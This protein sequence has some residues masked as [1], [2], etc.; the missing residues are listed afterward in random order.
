MALLILQLFTSRLF[1]SH[2]EKLYQSK[3]ALLVVYPD[4]IDYEV[5][6]SGLLVSFEGLL[7]RLSCGK[8][9]L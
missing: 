3:L 7:G 9:I 8:K 5:A 2:K 6:Q 4:A 1:T